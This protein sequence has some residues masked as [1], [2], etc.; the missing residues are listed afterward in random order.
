MLNILQNYYIRILQDLA[1]KIY[2]AREP[3]ELPGGKKINLGVEQY[4]NRLVAYIEKHSEVRDVLL[5]GGDALCISDEKLEYILK[6]IPPRTK[7]ETVSLIKFYT[8]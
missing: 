7:F 1:D 6:K 8:I 5:S 4:I 2:P 3:K